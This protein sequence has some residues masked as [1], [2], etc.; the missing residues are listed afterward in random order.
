MSTT[1]VTT[2]GIMHFHFRYSTE[3]A[4]FISIER[5]KMCVPFLFSET[6]N[7]CCQLDFS[8]PGAGSSETRQ[9]YEWAHEWIV[10]EMYCLHCLGSSDCLFVLHW[11]SVQKR[12]LAAHRQTSLL[13]Y[14][15]HL[16]VHMML[17]MY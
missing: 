13:L 5:G 8:S 6:N 2:V 9:S 10:K 15:I 3:S 4:D 1:T 11:L 16:S 14:Q 7:K 12:F 17:E